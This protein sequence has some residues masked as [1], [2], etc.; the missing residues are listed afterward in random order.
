MEETTVKIEIIISNISSCSQ[1]HVNGKWFSEVS[2][3]PNVFD[4][5]EAVIDSL[6]NDKDFKL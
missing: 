5:I 4:A 1:I 3:A 6:R 2:T